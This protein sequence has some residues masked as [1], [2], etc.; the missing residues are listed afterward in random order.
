MAFDRNTN[1]NTS[2]PLCFFTTNA[3]NTSSVLDT[4]GDELRTGVPYYAVSAIRGG[5]GGGLAIGHSKEEACPEIVVQRGS[6]LDRGI[7]VIFS[8]ADGQNGAV[9]QLSS[10]INIEFEPIRTKLCLTSVVWKLDNYDVST[11]KWW[12]TTDGV[13]GEPGA[14]TLNN[15]F[16][17]EKMD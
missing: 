1:Y 7:P 11:G 17:I 16:K 4:D 3:A 13:K 10:D 15:W 6:D 5:G 14:T 8:N 2:L 12:V 9:V